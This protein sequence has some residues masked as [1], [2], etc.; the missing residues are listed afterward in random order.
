MRMHTHTDTPRGPLWRRI[1]HHGPATAKASSRYPS[2]QHSFLSLHGVQDDLLCLTA[3]PAGTDD[4]ISS[5]RNSGQQRSA[6]RT[7]QRASDA[8]LYRAVVEVG[9]LNF[10]LKSAGEQEAILSGYAAFLN[11]LGYPV[12]LLTRVLP[13]DLA[14]YLTRLREAGVSASPAFHRLIEDHL[15]YVQALATGRAL[16]ERRFYLVIPAEQAPGGL[17]GNRSA[18]SDRNAAIPDASPHDPGALLQRLRAIT[19]GARKARHASERQRAYAAIAQ[20]L[21]LRADD[22]IR[23]LARFGVEGRRLRTAELLSLYAECLAPALDS[24]VSKEICRG[25]SGPAYSLFAPFAIHGAVD[26]QLR[27]SPLTHESAEMAAV[28]E[29]MEHW[30]QDVSAED[31]R[32]VRGADTVLDRLAPAAVEIKRDALHVDNLWMRALA[33]TGYPRSVTPGWLAI[34]ID[35]DQPFELSLHIRPLS[36]RA[37]IRQLTSRMVALHSSRLLDQRHG[38]LPDPE[39]EVAYSDMERLR[40][41]LQRGDE[42]VFSLALYLLVR[43][44][45]RKALD[46]RCA[47]LQATLDHLQLECRPATLEH[48]LGFTSC[49]PEARD[50]L[51]RYRTFDTSGL[52]TAFPFTASGLSMR[53]G[54]LYGVTPDTGSL[55]ILQPFAPELENAN[56]VVFAKSGAGKSYACKIQAL[57]ALLLGARVC[58]VDPEDEYRRLA[59]A[60]GGQVIRLAP[61]SAQRI[62]PFDLPQPASEETGQSHSTSDGAFT[63]SDT[64]RAAG[65][66][67]ADKIQALHAL[68]D[69]LLADRTPTGAVG[70][71]QREKGLLDRCL[72][73]T[74]RRVGITSDP[75]THDRPAPL[76]RDLYDTLHS[77]VC[78]S[79]TFGLA[80]RLE[81]YVHGSLASLFSA[82]TNVA[83][84]NPLVVFDVRDLDG[85]LRPLGLLLIADY[86]WTRVRQARQP[87]LL[88]IDEAWS[89]MQHTEGG[90]FLAGLARRARKHYLGLITITQDVEDFLGSEWGRVVLAN[91]SIQLLM[92]Q[93]ST[94]IDAVSDAFHL[95]TGERHYLLACHKGEGLLFAR[96]G[97]VQLRVEASQMEHALITTDP[98]ELAQRAAESASDEHKEPQRAAEAGAHTRRD[99]QQPYEEPGVGSGGDPEDEPEDEPEEDDSALEDDE[100]TASMTRPPEHFARLRIIARGGRDS[101]APDPTTASDNTDD[102]GLMERQNA[103][104]A[105]A[106]EGANHHEHHRRDGGEND[107]A[108]E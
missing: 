45:T 26:L 29:D 79:D 82:P 3:S 70:L 14:P 21:T 8:L 88:V 61:G 57:R 74:Y 76:L 4:T 31:M 32:I 6:R 22:V 104:Q 1:F 99:G 54:S 18:D 52:A 10:G 89:L 7:S 96:G 68:L 28:D 62:N 27:E 67:L 9:S 84:D 58:V 80:E 69:L 83:L 48:D 2:V 106:M 23:Q 25:E 47:R 92:K 38:R 72:Y 85:E 60:V 65:D 64:E 53:E 19:P 56:Q 93:D 81:R 55:V 15:R 51:G 13:L 66:A 59:T 41:A 30:A 108:T 33:V 24:S 12:Q 50:R 46:E 35:L 5:G 44:H 34:L 75:R 95:S 98:R 37:M 36:S 87:H 91:S 20:R 73:E 105:H 17:P 63:G 40:D 107:H 97:H 42:R 100:A 94:T 102:T 77:N 11:S 86:V 39:R 16:L 49:L 43:A 71:S 78:G 103:L 101:S 90:R